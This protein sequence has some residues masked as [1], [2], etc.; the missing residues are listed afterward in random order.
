MV[1]FVNT[2]QKAKMHTHRNSLPG[3]SFVSQNMDLRLWVQNVVLGALIGLILAR[4][5]ALI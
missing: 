1:G 3:K 5:E 4:V 2:N